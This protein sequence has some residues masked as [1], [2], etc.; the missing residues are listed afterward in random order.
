L[1]ESGVPFSEYTVGSGRARPLKEFIQELCLCVESRKTPLFGTLP[2]D[3]V[4]LPL[5]AF[6]TDLLHK[7]TG[8]VP[9]IN[10]EEGVQRTM[11]WIRQTVS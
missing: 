11:R 3:G 10:F 8:F 7:D 9:A 4:S 1:G 2:F 5:E 6:H